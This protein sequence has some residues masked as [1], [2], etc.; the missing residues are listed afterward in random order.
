M[1]QVNCPC[2]K[3][4]SAQPAYAGR[5]VKCP[6]C[7]AALTVPS[8]ATPTATPTAPPPAA[9]NPFAFGDSEEGLTTSKTQRGL[10]E[11][12]KLAKYWNKRN[13]DASAALPGREV[14]HRVPDGLKEFGKPESAFLVGAVPSQVSQY[15][16]FVC[17]PI[18]LASLCVAAYFLGIEAMREDYLWVGLLA[19]PVGAAAIA[20]WVY[21]ARLARAESNKMALVY[22]EGVAVVNGEE[23]LYYRWDEIVEVE[24]KPENRNIANTIVFGHTFTV[25]PADG[26]NLVFG[27]EYV[28]LVEF[29]LTVMERAAAAGAA[30]TGCAQ[31]PS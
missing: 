28:G 27:M 29:G 12:R 17:G 15:G 3:V 10:F 4:L 1:I 2:G 26:E 16:P 14:S 20:G 23:W 19:F 6:K 25:K 31:L 9:D 13:G 24:L 11:A 7:G 21:F 22:D 8:T 5:R 18:L 30:C